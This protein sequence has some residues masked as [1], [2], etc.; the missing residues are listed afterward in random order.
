M[1]KKLVF[2]LP[3]LIPCLSACKNVDNV[4]IDKL[5]TGLKD[6]TNLRYDN[7]A[8]YFDKVDGAS[9]YH[10]EIEYKNNIVFTKDI[11]VNQYDVETLNLVGDNVAYV[12]AFN[13]QKKSKK[14]KLDFS[15]NL[16]Q[17]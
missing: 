4:N 8:I 10:L 5:P 3:F 15:F 1:N 2:V 14:S 6:V 12:T 9:R 16:F 17:V 13:N 7:Q 11:K